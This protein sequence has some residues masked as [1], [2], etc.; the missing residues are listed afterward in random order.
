MTQKDRWSQLA[1]WVQQCLRQETQR[2]SKA[3]P[4]HT[5]VSIYRSGQTGIG[6][7]T[8][9]SKCAAVAV[10]NDGLAL[11]TSAA[12]LV[13]LISQKERESFACIGQWPWWFFLYV[14]MKFHWFCKNIMMLH[15]KAVPIAWLKFCVGPR[16]NKVKNNHHLMCCQP[17]AWYF[18]PT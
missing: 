2:T 10:G 15:M 4:E 14:K 18:F 3:V 17:I 9:I 8:G 13:T 16:K 12:T 11:G 6:A 5:I 1:G 7:N